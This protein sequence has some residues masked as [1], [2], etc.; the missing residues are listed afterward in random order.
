[1]RLL[2]LSCRAIY[3][4]GTKTPGRGTGK[5]DRGKSSTGELGKRGKGV[6]RERGEKRGSSPK[7]PSSPLHVKCWTSLGGK[8]S[9]LPAFFGGKV[10]KF[11]GVFPYS[12]HSFTRTEKEKERGEKVNPGVV[13]RCGNSEYLNTIICL[14]QYLW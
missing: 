12:L 3:A 10:E 2:N 7:L 4:C 14:C 8:L 5:P 11:R 6:N 9:Y 13:W 1:M